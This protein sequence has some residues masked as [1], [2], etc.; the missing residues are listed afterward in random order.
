MLR[1]FVVVVVGRAGE[2]LDFRVRAT[3]IWLADILSYPPIR[4][5]EGA[6]CGEREL[7]SSDIE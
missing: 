1:L 3:G 5:F 7:E 2:S 4:A 6:D